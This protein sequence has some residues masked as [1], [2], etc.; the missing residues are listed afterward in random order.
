MSTID[1][2]LLITKLNEI[3][4]LLHSELELR[5]SENCISFS[6]LKS[7][8]VQSRYGMPKSSHRLQHITITKVKLTVNWPILIIP[9]ANFRT[10]N[11]YSCDAQ[12]YTG[13]VSVG[14]DFHS[15]QSKATPNIMIPKIMNVNLLSCDWLE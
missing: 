11:Q 9:L 10:H 3:L 8:L 2:F 4:K 12:S 13:R 15:N 6:L 1:L 14:A 5:S 7:C